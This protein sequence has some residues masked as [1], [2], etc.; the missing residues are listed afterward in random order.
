MFTTLPLGAFERVHEVQSWRHEILHR[1]NCEEIKR[2]TADNYIWHFVQFVRVLA[3]ELGIVEHSNFG[4]ATLSKDELSEAEILDLISERLRVVTSG[5]INDYLA[6]RTEGGIGI[7]TIRTV[8]CS[9]RQAFEWLRNQ[10]LTT[11]DEREISA[12]NPGHIQGLKVAI[13][14]SWIAS[15]EFP[16]TIAALCREQFNAFVSFVSDKTGLRFRTEA[17]TAC[18][19][20]LQHGGKGHTI[21][22]RLRQS[23]TSQ[24]LNNVLELWPEYV[25]VVNRR[26]SCEAEMKRQLNPLKQFYIWA[27]KIGIILDIRAVEHPLPIHWRQTVAADVEGSD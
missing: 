14:E 21:P 22:D 6:R 20:H 27:K 13:L 11:L 24:I 5:D 23:A 12:P 26:T 3:A 25:S 2:G 16:S 7:A 17:E 4:S 8:A 10:E 1:A 15:E 18:S 9:L 19:E